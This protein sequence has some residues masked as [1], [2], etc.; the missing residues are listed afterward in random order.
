[1]TT[2]LGRGVQHMFAALLYGALVLYAGCGSPG[3]TVCHPDRITQQRVA[4]GVSYYDCSGTE[5]NVH[6]VTIDRNRG[7]S[8][9]WLLDE[10]IPLPELPGTPS[11]W[12]NLRTVE[13]HTRRYNAVVGINGYTWHGDY[14]WPLISGTGTPTTTMFE[15][16]SR[17]TYNTSN[18]ENF[19]DPC[20]EA[21]M[22]FAAGPGTIE[23][24][25][26]LD[27]SHDPSHDRYYDNLYGSNTSV[28]AN[29]QCKENTDYGT[30]SI[31]GYSD[32]QIVFLTAGAGYTSG[33]LCPVLCNFGVGNAIEQDGDTAAAM[34]I[35][36]D[37]DRLINPPD[38][39]IPRLPDGIVEVNFD[40]KVA[41][42]VGLVDLF[43][44]EIP[45]AG[46]EQPVLEDEQFVRHMSSDSPDTSLPGWRGSADLFRGTGSQR[47]GQ[48]VSLSH[49]NAC[50][51][52]RFVEE[53]LYLETTLP[54]PENT[55]CLLRFFHGSHTVDD[56]TFDVQ[57]DG[58]TVRSITS[59]LDTSGLQEEAV[60][61]RTGDTTPVTLRFQSTSE[62]C[63]G[64]TIDD[65]S[66]S[67]TRM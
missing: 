29:G 12:L 57:V 4:D 67:C 48:V 1:M 58:Q 3:S 21:L 46:F 44:F 6:V 10:Q 49:V 11:G 20:P 45:N 65:V 30:W 7:N 24:K 22:G 52:A 39:P 27:P 53:D 43:P 31:V 23:A 34:F 17:L 47:E 2:V 61:F 56:R 33:E 37:L 15:A 25:L 64:S 14:G 18:C 9:I 50:G 5:T 26:A 35:G 60:R 8:E 19:P 66:I 36:G 54:L 38:N 28:I 63:E 32:T 16:R 42:V 51:G 40:R 62:L 55:Y 13:D 41:Y 59:R